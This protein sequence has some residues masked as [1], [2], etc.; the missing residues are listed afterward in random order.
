MKQRYKIPA[1]AAVAFVTPLQAA[2]IIK[3]TAVTAAG[4]TVDFIAEGFDRTLDGSG[5]ASTL[6]TGD[7]VPASYPTH[8]IGG[9]GVTVPTIAARFNSGTISSSATVTYDLGGTYNLETI[10]FYN[11]AEVFAGVYYNDRGLASAE[12]LTSAN[13]VD[14]SSLGNFNFAQVPDATQVSPDVQTLTASGVQFV[15]FTAMT[16]H[17]GNR[18]GWSEV[19]FT[20]EVIPEP[21]GPLLLGLGGLAFFFRRRR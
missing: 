7:A 19:R 6:A 17:G 12:I 9:N 1:L 21:S 8:E 18:T 20:G 11:Y 15:R 4:Q 16:S 2:T 13:G 14:F 3:P 10:A 5:L